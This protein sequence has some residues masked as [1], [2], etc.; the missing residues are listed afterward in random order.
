MSTE[1]IIFEGYVFQSKTWRPHSNNP[2]W[3]NEE[4]SEWRSAQIRGSGVNPGIYTTESKAWSANGGRIFKE[5]DTQY[6]RLTNLP[7]DVTEVYS[8]RD[9]TSNYTK[10]R[11]IKVKVVGVQT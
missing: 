9:G 3:R 2:L 1:E 11:V 8:K 6:Q 10:R 4:D 7:D 5:Y